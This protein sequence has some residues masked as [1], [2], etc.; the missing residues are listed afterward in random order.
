MLPAMLPLKT[1]A[2]I[3]LGTQLLWAV[4]LAAPAE[5]TASQ[6]AR[7]GASAT[8][9][10]RLEPIPSGASPQFFSPPARACPLSVASSLIPAEA[11]ALIL[12][13]ARLHEIIA[14]A[15]HE[16]AAAAA[17]RRRLVISVLPIVALDEQRPEQVRAALRSWLAVKPHL[18]GALFVGNVK[19][20]SFFL[21]RADIH[22]VRLWPRY[23][24]DLDMVVR[25]RVAPGTVLKGEDTPPESWP[26]IAGAR[27]LVVPAHDFDDLAEGPAPG[28]DLWAAFL[29]VGFQDAGKNTYP[30]WARQLEGFF[31]KATAFHT[32]TAKYE[33]GLYLISND[34]GLLARSLPVWEAVGPGQIEFFAVNEQGPGAFKNNPAGYRRARLEKYESLEAFLAYAKTLPWMDEGWQS[35]DVFI[36]HMAQSRR[37]GVVE[38]AF[39]SGGVDPLLATGARPARRRADSAIEW[40]LGRRF[41][42]AGL[43]RVRGHGGHRRA[44]PA[45]ERGLWAVGLRGSLGLHA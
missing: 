12:V 16:Y 31:K 41:L 14:P 5:D 15:L 13:D 6:N 23:F 3:G 8:G 42:S 39:Q 20:P 25:R 40:V 37:R 10:T 38:C 44:E 29:P 43:Q 32:G 28:P 24:E 33:R 34:N 1:V 2:G 9:A 21:P 7:P 17:T 4:L 30:D 35:A 36:E 26:K 22:S 45:G 19:L 18:E 11:R 27:E